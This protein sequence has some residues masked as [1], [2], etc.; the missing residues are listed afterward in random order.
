MLFCFR[1]FVVC[2]LFDPLIMADGTVMA[3]LFQI[4]LRFFKSALVGLK[5]F[6]VLFN[7]HFA[8]P[9]RLVGYVIFAKVAIL[10]NG[11]FTNVRAHQSTKL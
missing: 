1:S 7:L 8:V 6:D 10:G 4:T 11:V 2:L 9:G 3:D 5:A